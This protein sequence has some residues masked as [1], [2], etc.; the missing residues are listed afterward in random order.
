MRRPAAEHC[1]RV[2]LADVRPR[3]APGA[4]RYRLADGTAVHLR[5]SVLRG[6][7]GGSGGRALLLVCPSC[8]RGC[9][10]L[11]RP[12]AAGWG[13]W[14]CRPISAPSHRRSG[15]RAGRGKPTSWHLDRL[16]AEQKRIVALLG[17]AYFPPPRLLWGLADLAATP[18]RPGAPRL[19]PERDRALLLRLDALASMRLALLVP[20]VNEYLESCGGGPLELGGLE[21]LRARALRVLAATR[22][23]LRRPAG[24][25]RYGRKY[26]PPR[27]VE[28]IE[29]GF[30]TGTGA[31]PGTA[32]SAPC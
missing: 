27:P 1:W 24:D 28:S 13:C 4:E 10:V 2:T 12:P 3:V 11:W 30:V 22:W 6:C 15:A 9:R 26:R 32:D 19:S 8:S 18:R 20:G 17:L 14:S 7:F 21:G 29:S 31:N 23:A 5:W 25:R 16:A